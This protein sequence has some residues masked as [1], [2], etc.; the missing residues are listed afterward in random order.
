VAFNCTATAD[1][2]TGSDCRLDTSVDAITPG[3]IRENQ[4]T[5]LQLFRL[6]LMDSGPDDTAGN[7]DDRLFAT[8]G[9]Y[10]P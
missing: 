10:V 6:R 5:V 7:S 2:A 8:Q 4:A 9:F 1:S 3:L